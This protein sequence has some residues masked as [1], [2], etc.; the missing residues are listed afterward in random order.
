MRLD[1]RGANA[2]GVSSD[3]VVVVGRFVG[4]GGQRQDCAEGML[5]MKVLDPEGC[6]N[7]VGPP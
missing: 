3:A 7:H 1:S 5:G 2:P 6:Q 4:G